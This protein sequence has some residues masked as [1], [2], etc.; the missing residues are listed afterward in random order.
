MR[1]LAIQIL[2]LPALIG[3]PQPTAELE[4]VVQRVENSELGIVLATLAG[5]FEVSKNEGE[6]LELVR[7]AGLPRGRVWFETRP[8]IYLP[9]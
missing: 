2:F 3:C 5:G 9:T 4:P 1:A 8:A 6:T 7:S